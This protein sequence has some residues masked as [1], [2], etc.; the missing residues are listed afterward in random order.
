MQFRTPIPVLGILLATAVLVRATQSDKPVTILFSGSAN[1][2]LRSCHCPSSPWGGLA[3]RAWLMGQMRKA[4]GAGNVIAMDSGDLFPTDFEEDRSSLLLRVF[5]PMRYRAVAL[6]DQE[7]APGLEAWTRINRKAGFWDEPAGRSTFPWLSAGYRLAAGPRRGEFLVPP[8]TRFRHGDLRVGLVS[9]AGREAWR[10]ARSVPPELKLA[11]PRQVVAEFLADSID[12]IDMTIVLSHQGIDADRALAAGCAGIDLIIGGHSQ[13]LIAPP[14]IVNGTAIC[15]AGKNGEN[16]GVLVI[17]PLSRD[18]A[19][20]AAS[21]GP[22]PLGPAESGTNA[23][24]FLPVTIETPRWRIAQQII[25]LDA[26]VGDA[27]SV[28]RRIAAYYA[29]RDARRNARL[30]RPAPRSV[31]ADAQL[32]LTIPE[33]PIVLQA[34][35]GRVVTTRLANPGGAPL[36]IEQVRSKSPWLRV[37]SVPERIEPGAEGEIRFQVIAE[38]I[39][40]FFRC[41]FSIVSND[42]L[43][44]V[45]QAAFPGRVEGPMPG[46]LDVPALWS[47]LYARAAAPRDEPGRPI[48]PASP[49]APT[50]APP[51]RVLVEYFYAPGCADC[52]EIATEVL[53][54]FTNHFAG[55]V[56]FRSIDVTVPANYLHLA[57]MQERLHVRS[58]ASVSIY[59]DGKIPLLGKRAIR[60]GLEQAVIERMKTGPA[61][62]ALDPQPSSSD[63]TTGAAETPPDV[64][65]RRIESFALPAILLAGLVDGLNPCA[66]ATIIFFITLLAV[67]GIRGARLLLVGA[68]Y[69]AAVFGTYLLLGF[70]ALQ[71][72]RLM[73]GWT[74]AAQALRWGMTVLLLLLAFL[75]L[76]DA[77]K[78]SRSGHAGDVAIQLP[79]RVKRKIHEIMRRGLKAPTLFL[80]AVG[81]GVLVTLLETVCTGQVYLPTLVAL[82]RYP[83][84]RGKSLLLLALYN[85]MF[86]LPL[87][88][89][90]LA[91]FFGARNQR[92]LKWSRRNVVWGKLAMGL[93]FVAMALILALIS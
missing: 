34:G 21:D 55:I 53:P 82:S 47:N 28:A 11:E 68:A 5:G 51:S 27:E 92:L 84:T 22:A 70:G 52:K 26:S 10:F 40:R 71:A 8:W 66:F 20:A 30:A 12:R 38:E 45:V 62:P 75:S 18:T 25:P 90:T 16:L 72:L 80:G 7:L 76:R 56:D 87:V 29:E 44:R 57:R 39:D 93:F 65:A 63:S 41:E 49:A 69:T 48:P 3:K 88:V 73:T 91:A 67:A 74:Q 14:E 1:G 23:N 46:I 86:V 81:I 35:A 59:V 36:A 17:V 79:D 50:S 77:W 2:V 31:P 89:V 64:L 60:S 61:A 15:Q 9:V 54:D 83:G 13:S 43:R 24:P 37:L 19:R 42:P 78:F 6:G 33:Q 58:D 4:A 32:V 85:L